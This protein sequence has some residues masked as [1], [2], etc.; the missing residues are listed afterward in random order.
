MTAM[1]GPGP[2][3]RHRPDGS[4]GSRGLDV[5]VLKNLRWGCSLAPQDSTGLRLPYRIDHLTSHGL[6]LH[7]TDAPYRWPWSRLHDPSVQTV[8]LAS[9]LIRHPATLAM[10]ESSAH[11]L[12]LVLNCVPAARRPAFLVISCWLAE[13]VAAADENKLRLYRAAYSAVDRLY[14]FSRDQEAVLLDAL[15]LPADRLAFLPFG[16]DHD[17]FRPLD[18]SAT[19]PMLIAGRDKGRDWVT[20]LAALRESG[21]PAQ[22]LCRPEDLSGLDVPP[23]VEVLGFVSRERYK[24]IL[25]RARAVL[26]IT[27]VRRYPTGQS[28]LLE[29]MACGR[30]VIATLTPALSDYLESDVTAVTVPPGD[31]AALVDA[32][33]RV[34]SGAIDGAALGTAGRRAVEAHFTAENMWAQVARDIVRIA[35][36]RG[37]H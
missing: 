17:E 31:V 19:G 16:I 6:R 8:A 35:A 12:G 22:V 20:A 30:P 11:P 33:R 14:Y 27:K 18:T 24:S 21:L 34:D 5:S 3:G 15:G 4:A 36:D 23:N 1:V 13:L 28:V 10:F 7:A 29:A 2:N 37:K 32:V 9:H 25:Q 26:V